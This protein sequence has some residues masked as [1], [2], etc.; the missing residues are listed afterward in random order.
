MLSMT[1]PSLGD[2]EA[3]R[4]RVYAHLKATPLMRHPLLDEWLGCAAWVKHENHQ[5]TGAFKIRGGV[6]LV[7]Q[8]TADERRRGILEAHAL[9]ELVVV[10][11]DLPGAL[12]RHDH[13]GVA[14][15]H[16]LQQGVDAGMDHRRPMVPASASSRSTIAASTSVARSTS[17]L[18]TM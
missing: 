11:V 1:P 14:R 10:V 15:V 16:V 17:S 7:A 8:L 5:P 13:E 6:N 4:P 12:G 9:S 2:I 3:A 18:R